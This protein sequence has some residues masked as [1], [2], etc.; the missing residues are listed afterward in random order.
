[1]HCRSGAAADAALA[2]RE[3]LQTFP[4]GLFR[5]QIKASRDWSGEMR[6]HGQEKVGIGRTRRAPSRGRTILLLGALAIAGCSRTA[7]SF[8]TDDSSQ[9]KM[10][11]LWALVQF[12]P[13]PSQP[14][15]FAPV[16]C[17]EISIQDGTAEDRIYGPGDDRTNANVRY[18]LSIINFARD[19]QVVD[20]QYQMKVGVEGRVLLGPAGAP[21]TYPA[22][23]RVVIVS[24]S[25]GSA[26]V[27][28]LYQVPASVAEGQTEGPFT[29][30]TDPLSVP[31]TGQYSDQDYVIKIGFDSQANAGAARVPHHR[32]HAAAA[33]AGSN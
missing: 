33:D 1:M 23:V 22:P 2:G 24:R 21:G 15:P 4:K 11:N 28:K 26:T 5:K 19:C 7:G 12:K 31:V 8:D 16:K 30:I 27:S 29:I 17:P 32:H 25:D 14:Q 9:T 18:Q 13:I 6:E 20:K 10:N 3:K